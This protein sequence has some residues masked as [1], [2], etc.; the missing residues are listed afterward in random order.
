M[1][2]VTVALIAAATAAQR[3]SPRRL[4]R[5]QIADTVEN[6]IRNFDASFEP[7]PKAAK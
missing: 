6:S 7:V 4:D 3:H 5:R 2:R 1:H